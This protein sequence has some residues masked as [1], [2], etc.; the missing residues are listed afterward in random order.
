MA[1]LGSLGTA[2]YQGTVAV[3]EGLSPELA[4][5]VRN[6]A[7]TALVAVQTLPAGAAEEA[8]RVLDAA[9]DAYTNGLNTAGA[10][11]AVIALVSAAIAATTLRKASD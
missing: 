7:D 10:V 2:V 3:P 1:L 8:G 4:E 11:C 5:A 9:R 6:G